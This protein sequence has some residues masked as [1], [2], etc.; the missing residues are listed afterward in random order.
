[1]KS[2]FNKLVN[3][4]RPVLIDFFATWC[5]P[6]KA[7]ARVLKEVAGEVADEVRIIKIDVDKNPALAQR[8]QIRGVPT[9]ALFKDGELIWRKSGMMSKQELLTTLRNQ[10]SN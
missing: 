4:E 6:C 1:M 10:V 7:L 8:F 2:S 5:G 3:A 9:L